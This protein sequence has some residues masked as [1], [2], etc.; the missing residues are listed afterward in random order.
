M[1]GTHKLKKNIQRKKV[2]VNLV[3]GYLTSRHESLFSIDAL[4]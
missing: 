4:I 1:T 3:V 2:T